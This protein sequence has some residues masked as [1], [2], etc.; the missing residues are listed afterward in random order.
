MKPL[1]FLC[2]GWVRTLAL[3]AGIAILLIVPA[4]AVDLS[5]GSSQTS[6]PTIS[7]G[8]P[9]Y[10]RGIATGHPFNGLQIW[11]IGTNYVKIDNVMVNDDDSYTL[12]K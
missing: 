4:H 3:L 8:D 10:I 6:L 9:V 12:P 7:P 11:L 1:V 2:R 5:P